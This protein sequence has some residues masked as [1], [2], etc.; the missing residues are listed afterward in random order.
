M[1]N[2]ETS[3]NRRRTLALVLAIGMAAPLL[4]ACG[5]KGR[6]ISPTASPPPSAAS[7]PVVNPIQ[8]TN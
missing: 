8:N 7:N 2:R 4:A 1:K 3:L 5:Q 6:L